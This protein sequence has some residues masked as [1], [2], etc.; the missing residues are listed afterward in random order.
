MIQSCRDKRTREFA[1]GL[2]IREFHGF[3][4]QASRRLELL[5]N[6]IS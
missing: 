4:A 5:D 6:G 3:Y 2:R 1:A